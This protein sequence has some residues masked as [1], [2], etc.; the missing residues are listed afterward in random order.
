MPDLAPPT[1]AAVG[2]FAGMVLPQVAGL[3]VRTVEPEARFALRLRPAGIAPAEAA[4]S[5]AMPTTVGATS[6]AGGCAVLSLGPDEW[7]IV[8]TPA[9]APA[10]VAAFAGLGVPFA[11]V[12]VS[13]REAA[14]ELDG[15]LVEAVLGADCPLDVSLDAFPVG[16]ATRSLYG[17]ASVLLW[18]L[19]ADCVRIECGRS[20][21]PYLLGR[22]GLA[23]AHVAAL[24]RR[25]AALRP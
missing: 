4:L 18:R 19:D 23:V 9:E 14:L 10:I 2:P 3:R 11:L 12:D 17:K 20:F 8:V 13:D 22:L 21:A 16:R 24:A 6:R 7:R 15:P 5:V 1:L 25:D